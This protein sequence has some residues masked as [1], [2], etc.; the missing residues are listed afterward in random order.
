MNNLRQQILRVVA[1]NP[2][3]ESDFELEYAFC[4]NENDIDYILSNDPCIIATFENRSYT[5]SEI[6]EVLRNA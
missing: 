2:Q 6:L 4:V 3:F 5:D 1:L